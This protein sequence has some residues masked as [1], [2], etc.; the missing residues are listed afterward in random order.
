METNNVNKKIEELTD[1]QLKQVA[2]GI[3][4]QEPCPLIGCK[5]MSPTTCECQECEEGWIFK[6]S[7]SGGQECVL[8][9]GGAG[10]SGN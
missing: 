6:K 4:P 8:N 3:G 7:S 1:E 5:T 9:Q 10:I 2:G